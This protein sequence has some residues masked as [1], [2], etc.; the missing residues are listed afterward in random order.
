M[1]IITPHQST[2]HHQIP[3]NPKHTIYSLTS[4]SRPSPVPELHC[5]FLYQQTVTE[6]APRDCSLPSTKE[7]L[8][9]EQQPIMCTRY[10]EHTEGLGCSANHV[11]QFL[12]M[13]GGSAHYPQLYALPAVQIKTHTFSTAHSFDG[14]KCTHAHIHPCTQAHTH[15]RTHTHTH[16]RT[17]THT[18][19]HTRTHTHETDTR[20]DCLSP[21]G[22]TSPSL[23]SPT[24]TAGPSS[25]PGGANLPSLNSC[26]LGICP[27]KC[28]M[29]GLGRM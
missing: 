15:T 24:D 12:R 1:S 9:L 4:H 17:H 11:H 26:T 6:H 5:R 27:G 20:L 28:A 13:Y 7:S 29:K 18:H 8:Q 16:T 14:R 25:I 2:A 10:R 21:D 19:T 22:P 3:S 23:G